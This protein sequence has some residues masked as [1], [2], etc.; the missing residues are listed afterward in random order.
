MKYKMFKRDKD[1]YKV[2][3]PRTDDYI[4]NIKINE[5]STIRINQRYLAEYMPNGEYK[6]FWAVVGRGIKSENKKLKLK[7]KEDKLKIKE[8]KHKALKEGV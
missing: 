7:E 6:K 2:F 8:G 3:T 1:R 5:N 4:M